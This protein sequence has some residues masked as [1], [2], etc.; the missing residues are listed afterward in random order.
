VIE[1]DKVYLISKASLRNKRG[2]FNQASK[3]A[4]Y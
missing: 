4:C 1:Q 2:T 3:N